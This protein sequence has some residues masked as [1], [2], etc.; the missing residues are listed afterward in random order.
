MIMD[1]A[2]TFNN[3][4]KVNMKLNRKKCSFGVK[5]GKFLGYVVMSEGI[6]ANPKKMKAVADMQSPRT[7]KEMQSLSGK[8]AA[9]N[10]FLSKSAERALPFFEKLK[11]I[12]KD[13]KAN[14]RWTDEAEQAFQEMKK[15]ILELPTLT[16]PGLKET[17]YVYLAISKDAVSEVLIADWGGDQTPIRYVS[18]TLHEAE[19]N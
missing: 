14:F 3:L 11:N 17:L 6:Q 5:E 10:H 16:T 9:L 15:L 7:L 2:E 8:L 12:T 13:N 4:R 19:R 1:I 18:R